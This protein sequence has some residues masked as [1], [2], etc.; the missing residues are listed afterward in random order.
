MPVAGSYHNA[1]RNDVMMIRFPMEIKIL[2]EISLEAT[3]CAET[4]TADTVHPR[5]L[6]KADLKE[7]V[8]LRKKNSGQQGI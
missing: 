1:D 4:N 5:R 6:W 8:Y 2:M 7:L 3:L